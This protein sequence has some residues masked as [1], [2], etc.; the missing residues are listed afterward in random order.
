MWY[1]VKP[2]FSFLISYSYRI[3]STQQSGNEN[4]DG[5]FQL[6]EM[7]IILLSYGSIVEDFLFY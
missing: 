3:T 2:A 1:Y 6:F 4:V 7:V 5:Q